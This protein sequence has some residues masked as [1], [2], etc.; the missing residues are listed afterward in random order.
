MTYLSKESLEELKKE[1]ES[2]KKDGRMEIAERLKRAKE[3]GDLSEN[4]EYTDAKDAQSKLESRIFELE[5]II[6]SAVLIKKN[7]RKDTVNIGSTVEAQKGIKTFR[8]TI[9]GSREARPE[10]N[11]ISN[12]SPLGEAFLDKKVGDTVEIETPSGKAKYKITKIE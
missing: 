8:Y 2:L 3:Y 1:L 10:A 11:L 12:E 6:R 4:S 5:E 7:F 9:V